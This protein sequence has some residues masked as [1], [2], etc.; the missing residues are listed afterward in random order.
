MEVRNLPPADHARISAVL[1]EHHP[2]YDYS[3]AGSLPEGPWLRILGSSGGCPGPGRACSGYLVGDEHTRVL[4]DC[5]PGVVSMLRSVHDY[6]RIDGVIVSHMHPDHYLDLV[7]YA[8]GLM[9]DMVESG[10]SERVPLYLPPGGTAALQAVDEAL[11][12]TGWKIPADGDMGPGYPLLSERLRQSP[13]LLSAI[14]APREYGAEVELAFGEFR[15]TF[16]PVEHTV[17]AFGMRIRWGSS[18]LAYTG[19]TTACAAA[20][21]LVRGAGTVLCDATASQSDNAV[22][23]GHMSAAEAGELAS[24]AGAGRLILTHVRG[25]GARRERLRT[26]ASQRFAG[27]VTV[28]SEP[29]LYPLR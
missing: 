18:T 4:L 25:E 11:G 10:G 26:E 27:D 15:I 3:R 9:A 19:D 16:L 24:A 13:G 14:F 28:A 2:G 17:P 7:P 21:N 8:Y 6:A 22:A 12:H 5:G 23:P 29:S 1:S 20:A